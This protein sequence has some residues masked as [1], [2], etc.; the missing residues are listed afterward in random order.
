M[1]IRI[2]LANAF[3]FSPN[4]G[5]A[6]SVWFYAIPNA[7]PLCIFTGIALGNRLIVL[8]II[9]AENVAEEVHELDNVIVCNGVENILRFAPSAHQ[10]QCAQLAKVLRY[11]RLGQPN[12]LAQFADVT[13]ATS[14]ATENQGP[15]RTCDGR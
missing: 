15:L 3:P 2:D 9:A 10:L 4:H 11:D 5:N 13:F 12:S 7:K 8:V 6:L 14:K 1:W